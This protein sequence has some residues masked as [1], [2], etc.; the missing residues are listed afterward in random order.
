MLNTL[1][2]FLDENFNLKRKITHNKRVEIFLISDCQ[3]SAMAIRMLRTL[4]VAHEIKVIK[5]DKDF[6]HLNKITNYTS[7]MKFYIRS[8]Y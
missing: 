5:S 7:S 4:Q 8:F 6:K 2:G 1:I 3:W